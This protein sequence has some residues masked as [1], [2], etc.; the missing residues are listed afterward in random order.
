[1]NLKLYFLSLFLL[2]GCGDG[3]LSNRRIPIGTYEGTF[4]RDWVWGEDSIANITLT[5]EGNRWSGTS[6]IAK[7]PA[8]CRGNYS[9]EGDKI[10]FQN[11]CPW[12][13]DFDW[14]LVLSGEYDLTKSDKTLEFSHD[15][16]SATSDT[17]ID[18]YRLV[19]K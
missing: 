18:Q 3:N 4:Q 11:E 1:M 9:I 12:T 19:K 13:A 7:Y 15:T 16:R 2:T 8:L 17:Y 10:T 5:F 14:T 6:N